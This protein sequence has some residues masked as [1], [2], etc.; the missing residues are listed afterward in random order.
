MEESKSLDFERCSEYIVGGNP[1]TAPPTT[2]VE[3]N[4]SSELLR[5]MAWR[6]VGVKERVTLA[7]S[8]ELLRAILGDVS[9][10]F[11]V[12]F[13]KDNGTLR[14]GL[15]SDPLLPIPLFIDTPTVPRGDRMPLVSPIPFAPNELTFLI[16][17]KYGSFLRERSVPVSI[18]AL[19]FDPPDDGAP[20]E[21]RRTLD[22]LPL[23]HFK[24][25]PLLD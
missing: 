19:G 20:K 8:P 4:E 7:M 21:L 23:V 3:T 10:R 1:R 18:S 25:T 12:P 17:L 13:F 6:R 22:G 24:H 2:P 15:W 9:R 5:L 16:C 11:S 14:S